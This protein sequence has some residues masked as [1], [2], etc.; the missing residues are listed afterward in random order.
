M[1]NPEENKI[2]MGPGFATFT[3]EEIL[4][5]LFLLPDPRNERNVWGKM[6]GDDDPG[7]KRADC[8]HDDSPI[9]PQPVHRVI[10]G[11]PS[12]SANAKMILPANGRE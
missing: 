7:A 4:E 10:L 2:G 3:L 12:T 5:V 9:P 8:R 11:V 1:I 6:P